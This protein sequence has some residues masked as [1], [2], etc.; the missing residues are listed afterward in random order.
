MA[1]HRPDPEHLFLTRRE[2]LARC[3]PGCGARGLG[4]LVGGGGLAGPVEAAVAPRP[5]NPLAPRPPQFP[6]KVKRVIHLFM[7]GGPSQVDT[8][9][10]KPMLTKYHGQSLPSGS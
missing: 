4:G 10:P 5:L 7:N 6:A 9:D 1:R 2:L 8:W 3:G